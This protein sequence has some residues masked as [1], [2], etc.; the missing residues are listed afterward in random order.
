MSAGTDDGKEERFLLW[1]DVGKDD[2]VEEKSK[3]G[4]GWG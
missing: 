1:D 4:T 2:L 3:V